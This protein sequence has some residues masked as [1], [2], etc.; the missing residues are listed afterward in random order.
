MSGQKEEYWSRLVHTYQSDQEY[1]VGRGT[2]QAI[3]ERLSEEGDLGDVIEFGCGGG[4]FTQAIAANARQVIATDL[5]DEMLGM[6][7]THLQGFP[8]IT[9]QKADCEDTSFPSERF[10]TVFIANVIHVVDNPIKVLQEGYQIVKDG[11]LLL[12]VDFTAYGMKWYERMRLAIRY[13]RKWG[14]PQRRGRTA[15]S[16]DQLVSFVEEV[17]FTTDELQV[18]GDRT[19]AIYLRARKQ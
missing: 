18:L 5:S 7:R 2:L 10:D 9:I 8:N 14:M 6:A 11:G 15:L 3:T 4:Y 1:I 12:V 13:L 17:G 19:K 16:P